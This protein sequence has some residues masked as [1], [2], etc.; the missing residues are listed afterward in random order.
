MPGLSPVV[1]SG[2]HSSSRCVGLSLS[3]PLLL[4]STGSRCAGSLIVAHGPSCSGPCGIFP[5]QGSNPC[6]LYWQADSQPLHHQGSP[7][8]FSKAT[9]LVSEWLCYQLICSLLH[10]FSC[11]KWL[12]GPYNE[13]LAFRLPKLLN[14]CILP[15]PTSLTSPLP[16]THSP[17]LSVC[18]SVCLSLS[19]FSS[20]RGKLPPTRTRIYRKLETTESKCNSS[21]QTSDPFNPNRGESQMPI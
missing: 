11:C 14:V 8:T 10:E 13:G 21:S 6:P 16:P 9:K 15:S 20:C 1:A 2:V 19:P 12:L 4:R 3:R 17:P 18:L 5:D 7:R